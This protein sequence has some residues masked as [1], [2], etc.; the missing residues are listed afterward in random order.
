MKYKLDSEKLD[1]VTRLFN[2]QVDPRA[3]EE[4]VK[5][6]ICADWNEGDEHQE[7]ITSSTAQEIVDWLA[8]FYSH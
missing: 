6:E 7:W 2:Q 1:E 5:A 4:L 8:S 3:T